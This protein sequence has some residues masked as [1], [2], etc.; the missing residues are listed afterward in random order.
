MQTGLSSYFVRLRDVGRIIIRM[1][2]RLS[3]IDGITGIG[4]S[5]NDDKNIEKDCDYLLEQW[6]TVYQF[7]QYEYSYNHLLVNSSCRCHC[8][9]FAVNT[10]LLNNT[11]T[12]SQQS[13]GDCSKPYIFLKI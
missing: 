3:E 10:V 11:N 6:E 1:L 2:N 8:M 5:D 13:C 7:V 4:F 12:Y 9:T